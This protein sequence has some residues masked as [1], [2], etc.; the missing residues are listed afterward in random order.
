MLFNPSEILTIEFIK[1]Q[2]LQGYKML[3]L[4]FC[5]ENNLFIVPGPKEHNSGVFMCLAVMKNQL[6]V[7]AQVIA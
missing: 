6:V 7:S 2:I 4:P 1:D 5:L 3:R